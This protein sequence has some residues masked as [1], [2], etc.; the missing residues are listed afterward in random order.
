MN[1]GEPLTIEDINDLIREVHLNGDG[2][3]DYE[4]VSVRLSPCAVS[5][6]DPVEVSSRRVIVERYKP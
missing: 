5:A 6:P 2:S 3:I 4:E 1:A